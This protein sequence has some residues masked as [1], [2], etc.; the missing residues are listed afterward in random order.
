MSGRRGAG[1]ARIGSKRL[2]VGLIT[3]SSVL[4]CLVLVV[5]W[6]IPY[7]GFTVYPAF[8]WLTGALIALLVLGVAWVS[9]SMVM[10]IISGDTFF[11]A[12]KTRALAARLFLPLSEMLGRALGIDQQ[13]VRRSFIQVN[14]D[15]T[16]N[17]HKRYAPEE[18][19]V[20]LPHCIQWSGCGVRVSSDITRCKRCGNC[21]VGRLISLAER[22]GAHL[23]IATGGT[24]ARRIVV[25]TRPKMILAVACERD[26]AS[27]IQDTHP[28]PVYGIL[29]ER[30]HGPCIDTTVSLDR[31]EE[32]LKHFIK[33][34]KLP[35]ALQAGNP[36]EA[37]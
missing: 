13:A 17:S 27:G 37:A 25:Q 30:P 32:A 8:T 6:L 33:P 2:F 12:R 7:F 14:N 23:A 9:F 19:L 16:L 22:Y 20:L 36:E 10:Q 31:L 28:L 35:D 5:G 18:I 15:M 26:L 3:G 24:L 4:V 34:E 21:D 11:G 1:P 29:N